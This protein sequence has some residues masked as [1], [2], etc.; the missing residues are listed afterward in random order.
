MIEAVVGFIIYVGL[1]SFFT[2]KL[3]EREGYKERTY[4]TDEYYD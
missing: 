1:Y 3:A 2:D 4:S